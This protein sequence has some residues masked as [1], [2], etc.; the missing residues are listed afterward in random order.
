MK[1]IL[2]LLLA[3]V[4]LLC[5][6]SCAQKK[7]PKPEDD[8]VVLTVAGEEI[9]YDYF[10]YVYL[11]SKADLTLSR[12]EAF[13]D[14]PTADATLKKET[15]AV[16]LRNRA[17]ALLAEEYDISLSK[18]EKEDVIE[19]YEDMKDQVIDGVSFEEGL[20]KSFFTPYSYVYVQCFTELWL[21]I[22]DH[23]TAEENDII[24]ADDKTLLADIPV[25][26]RCIRYVMIERD[27]TDAAGKAAEK[28]KAEEILA[29]IRD[30]VSFDDMILKH[31]EDTT[32]ASQIEHG[33]YY[34]VTSITE[35]I[36]D[37]VETLEEREISEVVE[38]PYAY[39]I[40]QR[41]P[42]NQDYIEDNLEGFRTQYKARL[43]NEMVAAIEKTITVEYS[44]LWESL[45]VKTVK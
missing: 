7:M 25:N 43:F 40:I 9:Y 38:L 4:L 10:R 19:Y 45:T 39:F 21:A 17:I 24:R 27:A 28:A 32:M 41:L 30:G 16:I 8:R 13:W 22:Y 11:N 1:R 35:E 2:F 12:G 6:V 42:L 37:V 15:L 31:G 20:E 36:E 14:D 34:T 26:F 44:E 3:A 18:S 5:T 23:I 29:K 33:Y